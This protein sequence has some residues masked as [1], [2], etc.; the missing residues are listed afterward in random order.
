MKKSTLSLAAALVLVAV[1]F[2]AASAQGTFQFLSKKLPFQVGQTAAGQDTV[3]LVGMT[4]STALTAAK[5]TTL[6]LD[7]A[8]LKMSQPGFTASPIAQ[9]YLNSSGTTDS[10][11]YQVQW[12]SGPDNAKFFTT[13]Q[14]YAVFGSDTQQVVDLILPSAA[15]KYGTRFRV[16]VWAND[17]GGVAHTYQT[18]IVWRGTQ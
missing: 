17:T 3:S 9:L 13:S 12:S 18:G 15:T 8:G 2:T 5:D 16:I 1:S 4:T 7:I 11:G 10:V 14:A 6:W